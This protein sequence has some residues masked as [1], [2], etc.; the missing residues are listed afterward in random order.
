MRPIQAV[1]ARR[2]ASLAV[3]CSVP[4]RVSSTN[5]T[6]AGV[7]ARSRVKPQNR[8]ETR[9]VFA[10]ASR[11]SHEMASAVTASGNL[12]NREVPRTRG[13]K[14]GND[15]DGGDTAEVRRDFFI[16]E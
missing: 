7:V 14:S 5:R 13:N 3:H 12:S 8:R 10:Y 2:A 1:A 9:H 6:E 16:S 15:G 4:R 11:S